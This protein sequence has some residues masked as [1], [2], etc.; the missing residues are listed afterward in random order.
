MPVARSVL[1][2]S[3]VAPERQV[4]YNHHK[5]H[6]YYNDLG[7]PSLASWLFV[8]EHNLEQVDIENNDTQAG[9]SSNTSA[10]GAALEKRPCCS[11]AQSGN[12]EKEHSHSPKCTSKQNTAAG[13]DSVV[14]AGDK[15]TAE[16]AKQHES[17]Q[18]PEAN[19]SLLRAS[20][21][22]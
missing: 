15:K 18:N 1:G 6:S 2:G 8:F 10:S 20:F 19:L 16:C 9:N 22:P 13:S 5:Q 21:K 7:D 17:G 14:K 4:I 11:S 3:L 12:Q